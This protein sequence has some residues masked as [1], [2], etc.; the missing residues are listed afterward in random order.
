MYKLP[1]IN[2]HT[3]LLNN[4]QGLICLNYEGDEVESGGRDVGD[5]EDAPPDNKEESVAMMAA[6]SHQRHEQVSPSRGGRRVPPP[7]LPQK[8]WGKQ[9][10]PFSLKQRHPQK[11]GDET[12]L[13]GQTS[14][15]GM[16]WPMGRA[17]HARLGLVAPLVC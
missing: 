17:T 6:I 13:E 2:M 1:S 5:H 9:G 15:S 8:I 11:R 12:M 14:P 16:A 3:T 7:L 4:I 10:I